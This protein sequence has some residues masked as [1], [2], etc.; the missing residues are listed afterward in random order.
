M[1]P[2][3][4]S[5]REGRGREIWRGGVSDTGERTRKQ[6]QSRN[7]E[8][9]RREKAGRGVEGSRGAEGSHVERQMEDRRMRDIRKRRGEQ[10]QSK[11][12]EG[13]REDAGGIEQR[14]AA[15]AQG[16]PAACAG[17]RP[18]PPQSLRE[19]GQASTW[20]LTSG[21][22]SVSIHPEVLAIM[23]CLFLPEVTGN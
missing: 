18:C 16:S 5:S 15:A 3:T 20:S 19:Q 4:G 9:G 12:G 22:K 13:D 11:A 14:Y 17:G 23:L 1:D 7:T 21:S 10:R 2:I 6:K 8:G